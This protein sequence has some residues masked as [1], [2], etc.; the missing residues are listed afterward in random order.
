MSKAKQGA[1]GAYTLTVQDGADV[2][3]CTCAGHRI[4]AGRI[5]DPYVPGVP[6]ALLV[7]ALVQMGVRKPETPA[8]PAKTLR[9]PV[10]KPDRPRRGRSER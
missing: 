2:F 7:Q 4:Y 8:K 6:R 1:C 9:V 3:T 5:E 10:D